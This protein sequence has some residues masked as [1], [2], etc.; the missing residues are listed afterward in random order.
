MS[1]ALDLAAI[2]ER[3]NEGIATD[4]VV[5]RALVA[6]IR[7]LKEALACEK[8][9]SSAAMAGEKA[10]RAQMVETEYA[11]DKAIEDLGYPPLDH[12][13]IRCVCAMCGRIFWA[14]VD[15]WHDQYYCSEDCRK[16]RRRQLSVEWGEEF[17][18]GFE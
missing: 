12:S 11:R 16:E 15:G 2:E 17:P 6:E 5:V 8:H 1:D 9:L 7:R 4:D 13:S 14:D 18:E 10:A 3:A